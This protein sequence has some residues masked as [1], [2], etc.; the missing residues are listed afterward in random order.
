MKGREKILALVVGLFVVLVVLYMALDSLLLSEA[1][2]LNDRLAKLQSEADHKESQH[3]M[4][5]ARA[6]RLESLAKRTFGHDENRAS[7]QIRTRLVQ[8]LQRSGMGTSGIALSPSSGTAKAKDYCK[9]VGWTVRARG[10]LDQVV[11]FL[12]LLGR[13]PYIHRVENLSITPQGRSRDV[14]VS[15]RYAGLILPA[16]KGVLAG[17]DFPEPESV[18]DMSGEARAR[19]AVIQTRDLFRPYLR[20]VEPPPP[21]VVEVQPP[22][23]PQPPPEPQPVA[24]ADWQYR[25]VSLSDWGGRQEVHI[26]DNSTSQL[27]TFKPGDRLANGELVM[28]DYRQLPMPGKPG[29][30]SGS[31]A[32]IRMGRDYWAVEL[33]Q[34][35]AEKRVLMAGE[36]P[37]ELKAG[38]R[39]S[40][41]PRENRPA[42][43]INDNATRPTE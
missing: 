40:A 1:G 10:R 26:K 32:V 29:L 42:G 13:E 38:E 9:D 41:P 12:F 5:V 43:E 25:I 35:L 18:G 17:G 24:P 37:N 36:V 23:V 4:Y 19:Y 31:R 34:T 16:G 14:E 3:D 33:G 22:P 30:L 8:L 27:W 21:P 6:G 7:E 39:S 11:N 20:H 28:I 15:L 2:R